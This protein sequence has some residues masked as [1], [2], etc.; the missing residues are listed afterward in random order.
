MLQIQLH[1]YSFKH[2]YIGDPCFKLIL[3]I[4][5]VYFVN[6]IVFIY[7]LRWRFKVILWIST[8]FFI[9]IHLS[10]FKFNFR[11]PWQ[12][13]IKYNHVYKLRQNPLSVQKVPNCCNPRTPWWFMG[14]T[15]KTLT[16]PKTLG[17]NYS[18]QPVHSTHS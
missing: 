15:K 10:K 9:L 8:N 11:K 13:K 17:Q 3:W 5:V 16:F 12:L 4:Y 14:Y 1:F 7:F 18:T 2:Y 6:I